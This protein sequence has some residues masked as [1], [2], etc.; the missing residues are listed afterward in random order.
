MLLFAPL[1]F[2]KC[3]KNPTSK[4]CFG[5]IGEFGTKTTCLASIWSQK[6]NTVT[7]NWRQKEEEALWVHAPGEMPLDEKE[8]LEREKSDEGEDGG[9]AWSDEAKREEKTNWK[10]T[11]AIK[12]RIFL[13]MS[14]CV[15]LI[16][17]CHKIIPRSRCPPNSCRFSCEMRETSFYFFPHRVESKVFCGV[18]NMPE[19]QHGSAY[20]IGWGNEIIALSSVRTPPGHHV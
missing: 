6:K 10:K 7:H 14:P 5:S 3:T 15:L 8:I 20:F 2:G 1:Y 19:T 16:P 18:W 4:W 9:R 13:L 11:R 12:R 17:R